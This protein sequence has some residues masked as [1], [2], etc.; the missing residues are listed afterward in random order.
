V[1]AEHAIEY[2]T[3][4]D[5]DDDSEDADAADSEEESG[6]QE[7][8]AGTDSNSEEIAEKEDAVLDEA[9]NSADA[10]ATDIVDT[11]TDDD[12]VSGDDL[13]DGP[14]DET[15]R[16]DPDDKHGV[17]SGQTNARYWQNG[18]HYDS[19]GQYIAHEDVVVESEE[20]D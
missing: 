16:F 17:I 12:V 20:T 2:L 6:L 1:N 14:V 19:Q 11:N 3:K 9:D 8:D 10:D 15:P 7:T 13:V 5:A 18:C 4:L